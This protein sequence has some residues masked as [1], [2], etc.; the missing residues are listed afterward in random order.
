MN[1]NKEYREDEIVKR[2]ID[3][4]NNHRDEFLKEASELL[5][6]NKSTNS[7]Y[8]KIINNSHNKTLITDKKNEPNKKIEF[9]D[10]I[11]AY[12]GKNYEYFTKERFSICFLIF[13]SL[14]LFYRKYYKFLPIQI[15]LDILLL[16]SL[17]LCL[18]IIIAILVSSTAPNEGTYTFSSIFLPTFFLLLPIIITII[19]IIIA[20]NFNKKYYTYVKKEVERIKKENNNTSPEKILEICK[21]EGGTNGIIDIILFLLVLII[22]IFTIYSI[23]CRQ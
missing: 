15:L 6:N 16:F 7:S 1:K 14:Y 5:I 11:I 3:L 4:Y 10:Y 22:L 18:F 20:K 13:R 9:D 12:V 2:N 23:L 17:P 19:N 8:N 21:K